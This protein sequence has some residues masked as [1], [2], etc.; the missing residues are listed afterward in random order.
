M[1]NLLKQKKTV[2]SLWLEFA[3]HKYD[4]IMDAVS[5]FSS[6]ASLLL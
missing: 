5:G 4:H 3:V 2:F 6:N 1:T